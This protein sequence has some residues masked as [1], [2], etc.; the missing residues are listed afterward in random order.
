MTLA[1]LVAQHQLLTSLREAAGRALA[2]AATLDGIARTGDATK[3]KDA[4]TLRARL[5][6]AAGSYPQPMLID[7]FSNVWRMANQAD[8]RPGQD[9]VV[10][11]DDLANELTALEKQADALR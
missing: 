6:T 7:Q 8:Q 11:F 3:A 4:A 5:V 2:L 10:R 1:D 9:A